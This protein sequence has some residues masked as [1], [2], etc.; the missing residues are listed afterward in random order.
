MDQVGFVPGREARDNTIKAINIHHWLTSNNFPGFFISLDAE[1]AFDRVAWDYMKETLAAV[2]LPEKMRNFI[3]ALYALPT[4]KVRVNGHLSNAFPITNGTRQGCPLSP[5]IFILTLEPLLRCLRT[6]PDI[7]GIPISNHTYKLAAYA[8]DIL[9]FL[10][11]PLTTIPNLLKQFIE[12]ESLS[13]LQINFSKS[14]AL[15]ISLSKTIFHQCKN[16]FPFTWT[17]DSLTYLGI[18]LPVRLSNLYHKNF[19]PLLQNIDQNLK[20]WSTGIFSWFG[21]AAILKMHTLPKIL[22][23]FQTLPIKLPSSFFSSY[24]KKC[25]AFIWGKSKPRIKFDILTL[26]KKQGGIGLPDIQKFYQACHLTRV[27]DWNIHSEFKDWINIE[28]TFTPIPLHILPWLNKTHIPPD[29]K[30]HP[31]ID[32]TIN[33]FQSTSRTQ[34]ISS[35]PGPLTPVSHNPAFPLGMESSFAL[36]FPSHRI[37]R[38][39]LFFENGKFL[40]LTDLQNRIQCQ[41]LPQRVYLQIKRFLNTPKRLPIITRQHTSFEKICICTT[42]QRHLIS[43]S[44]TLLFAHAAHTTKDL[45]HKWETELSLTLSEKDWETIFTLRKI[46]IKYFQDGT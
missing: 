17:T 15:N 4:A 33:I 26:P 31:L 21:R 13:N 20:I 27:I 41:S 23:L 7:A 38:A 10:S 40:P 5:L 8:D 1:K 45:K 39:E 19:T 9:M 14:Q 2:G 30:F 25:T 18:Q 28:R 29:C 36:F 37:V 22:Y 46:V 3:H 44:Y 42:P 12:F 34:K 11:N 16:N 24:K 43:R 35:S 32:N 6:N